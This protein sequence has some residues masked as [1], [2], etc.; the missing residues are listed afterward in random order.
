MAYEPGYLCGTLLACLSSCVNANARQPTPFPEPEYSC[1][2][3][4]KQYIDEAVVV[5]LQRNTFR[6]LLGSSIYDLLHAD[7][8]HGELVK[9]ISKLRVDAFPNASTIRTIPCLK[10]L[11]VEL[12]EEDLELDN[13]LP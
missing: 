11:I 1:M 4:S 9:Y 12:D 2:L 7:S 10:T 5:Y 13:K 3:V 6:F 8:V